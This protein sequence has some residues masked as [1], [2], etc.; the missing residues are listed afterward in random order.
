MIKHNMILVE[1]ETVYKT[2]RMY[3]EEIT[4]ILA[5][6]YRRCR[7]DEDYATRKTPW[8][9]ERITAAPLMESVKFSMTDQAREVIS[10]NMHKLRVHWG[11]ME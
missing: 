4:K 5:T 2:R 10:G 7:V 1:P 11:P 6:E 8:L 9:P 3:C